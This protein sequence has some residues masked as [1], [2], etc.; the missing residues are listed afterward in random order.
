MSLQHRL[1]AMERRIRELEDW[2]ATVEAA[3][4]AEEAEQQGE[5]ERTLDGDQAGGERGQMESLG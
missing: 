5:P 2:K 4:E 1:S 3:I